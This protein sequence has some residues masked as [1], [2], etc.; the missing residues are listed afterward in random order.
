VLNPTPTRISGSVVGLLHS[1]F[2]ALLHLVFKRHHVRVVEGV[3]FAGV[4]FL[5]SLVSN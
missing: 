1:G 4:V 2:L 3:G 5:A